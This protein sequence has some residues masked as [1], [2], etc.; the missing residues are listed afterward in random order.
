MGHTYLLRTGKNGDN[1]SHWEVGFKS[2]LG[3]FVVA[4]TTFPFNL[5]PIYTFTLYLFIIHVFN[6]YSNKTI[7]II[8]YS[9]FLS[10][11]KSGSSDFL[12]F[13]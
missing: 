13:V 11:S 5:K 6:T 2:M 1:Q 12:V 4:L 7:K 3:M 8:I 10:L 9:F